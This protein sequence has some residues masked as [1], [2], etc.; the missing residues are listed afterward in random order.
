MDAMATTW[1]VGAADSVRWKLQ[2][3]RHADYTR[4]VHIV[5]RYVHIV[6]MR[7][8]TAV[9][10]QTHKTQQ[11][12]TGTLLIDSRALNESESTSMN[13]LSPH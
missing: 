12:K 6:A 4:Y 9:S 1:L 2:V 3:D 11:R 13:V 7:H 8:S 10:W 5:T